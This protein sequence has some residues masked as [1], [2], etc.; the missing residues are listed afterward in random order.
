MVHEKI[1]WK[2]QGGDGQVQM[3]QAH[4]RQPDNGPE[5]RAHQP[6]KNNHQRPCVGD[7]H[8]AV[9]QGSCKRGHGV[10][11]D[12]H[13]GGMP[14]GDQP[15]KAGDDIQADDR[16]DGNQNVVDHQHVLVAQ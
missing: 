5:N 12:P 7:E 2:A 8:M 4:G 15:G 10:G 11:P 6:G 16:N 3:F 9:T 14:D 1:I 13:K